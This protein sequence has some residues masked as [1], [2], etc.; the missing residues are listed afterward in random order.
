MAWDAPSECPSAQQ[1]RGLI[2]SYLD[3]NAEVQPLDAVVVIEGSASAWHM[4]IATDGQE[5]VV[6]G[7]TCDELARAAAIIISL[8]LAP[9][10][11]PAEHGDQAA[12]AD[13][14]SL[15]GPDPD[16][17]LPPTPPPVLSPEDEAPT[18]ADDLQGP[19]PGIAEGLSGLVR[20]DAGIGV[21]VTPT[22]TTARL[23]TGI[24]GRG[25]RVE[26]A[27]TLWAPA[28]ASVARDGLV[29]RVTLGTAQGRGCG[30]PRSRRVEFPLCGGVAL[31]AL[32]VDDLVSPRLV[33]HA[34][35]AG[36]TFSAALV[37]RFRPHFA[38][39]AGPE[40][41]IALQRPTVVLSGPEQ[42]SYQ[43]GRAAVRAALGI[44]FHF[45][46]RRARAA[47]KR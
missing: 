5:R 42:V 12:Q 34:F 46:S 11:P 31:G 1:E 44:E 36:A 45:S 37:W 10:P 9:E 18:P 30:V 40:A 13:P 4:T 19:L 17:E 32:R 25:Y 23:A 27:G 8:A 43:S 16:T 7:A 6:Q 15:E 21:G 2:T 3:E 20:V 14:E 26:L 33:T 38:L 41:T 47:G 22:F 24:A 39:W 35:W 29:T 28:D